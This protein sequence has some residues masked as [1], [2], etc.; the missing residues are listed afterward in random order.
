MNQVVFYAL[1]CDGSK[2]QVLRDGEGTFL[3]TVDGGCMAVPQPWN[4]AA[5][6]KFGFDY[7]PETRA[8]WM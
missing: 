3:R 5:F 6:L 7:V 4:G 8:S 1:Y 2:F